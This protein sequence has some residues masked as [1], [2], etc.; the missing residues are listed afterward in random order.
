[1]SPRLSEGKLLDTYIGLDGRGFCGSQVGRQAITWSYRRE[2]NG[3][4][5]VCVPM[6]ATSIVIEDDD[7]TEIPFARAR[8][9]V[10]TNQRMIIQ[11]Q[12]VELRRRR[13][14]VGTQLL[15]TLRSAPWLQ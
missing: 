1:M 13:N 7:K 2:E 3:K 8:T 6:V 9:D 4:T 14:A 10:Q 15:G 11:K 5:Y 12:L